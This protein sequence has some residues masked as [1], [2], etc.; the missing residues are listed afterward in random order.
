MRNRTLS[1]TMVRSSNQAM[2]SLL[3]SWASTMWKQAVSRKLSETVGARRRLL[4]STFVAMTDLRSRVAEPRGDLRTTTASTLPGSLADKADNNHA[5]RVR[6]ALPLTTHS[7]V[8]DSN[9]KTLAWSLR[10]CSSE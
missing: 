6:F 9:T 4:W 7:S 8:S 1:G 10:C 5:E 3:Q 2:S